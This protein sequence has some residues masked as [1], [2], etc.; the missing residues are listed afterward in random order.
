MLLAS[1]DVSQP[2]NLRIRLP[3]EV[4]RTFGNRLVATRGF[5]GAIDLFAPSGW[6]GYI[7]QIGTFGSPI[8]KNIRKIQRF[9]FSAAV[10]AYVGSR[11]VIELNDPLLS[12]VGV[13]PHLWKAGRPPFALPIEGKQANRRSLLS[14]L[15]VGS[16]AHLVRRAWWHEIRSD[17]HVA[18]RMR[19]SGLRPS[20]DDD[21]IGEVGDSI[22]SVLLRT[23]ARRGGR[24]LELEVAEALSAASVGIVEITQP[25]QDGGIDVI[26][27]IPDGSVV[28][29]IY[30]QCKGG[31]RKVNVREVRELIG[32]V[33][34]DARDAGLLVATSGF[35]KEA[36][37][38]AA[39]SKVVVD[40]VSAERL[41]SWV[42][43]HVVASAVSAATRLQ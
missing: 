40:L 43:M 12:R 34:R 3:S 22:A 13:S 15:C 23:G 2:S 38:E 14:L 26:V 6:D 19:I 42:E 7:A 17:P 35:S 33:A 9:L 8:D 11:N 36:T 24:R 16:R 37:D 5:N 4:V 27:H 21:R 10:E 41:A 1:Y 32:V 39:L 28:R 29:V 25:S 31:Q 18:E 20:W 30:V